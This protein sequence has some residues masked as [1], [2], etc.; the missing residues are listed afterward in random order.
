MVF[1]SLS[2]PSRLNDK[3]SLWLK[4]SEHPEYDFSISICFQRS[5]R[6]HH[7][8]SPAPDTSDSPLD[9]FRDRGLNPDPGTALRRAFH[10]MLGKPAV[11]GLLR[12]MIDSST[13]VEDGCF[14]VD[15]FKHI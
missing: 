11:P 8:T 3:F 12:R 9:P 6:T 10:P 5:M 4:G 7:S 2:T 13:F 15:V 1:P 14:H